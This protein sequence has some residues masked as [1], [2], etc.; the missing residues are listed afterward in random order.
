MLGVTCG[1]DGT[2]NPSLKDSKICDCTQGHYGPLCMDNAPVVKQ[3]LREKAVMTVLSEKLKGLKEAMHPDDMEK[4]E[5]EDADDK[6]DGG[7]MGNMNNNNANGGNM[8]NMNNN[9]NDGM[10]N[11][12]IYPYSILHRLVLDFYTLVIIILIN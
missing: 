8:E 3:C 10:A 5:D 2:C 6:A 4:Y 1:N 12:R 9:K 11:C 7:N